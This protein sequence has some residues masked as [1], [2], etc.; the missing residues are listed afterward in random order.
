MSEKT[1]RMLLP[2]EH[3]KTELEIVECRCG[4]HL[5]LDA[6]YLDQVGDVVVLCPSCDTVL[7]TSKMETPSDT[8]ETGEK[9]YIPSITPDT[10]V[11]MLELLRKKDP[12]VVQSMFQPYHP[13]LPEIG[14]DDSPFFAADVD[15]IA[16]LAN[17]EETPDGDTWFLSVIGLINSLFGPS[18]LGNGFIQTRWD[19][20]QI[21]G[22]ELLGF[23]IDPL[24][25]M[26]R[27]IEAARQ[28]RQEQQPVPA[29]PLVVSVQSSPVSEIPEVIPA[30]ELTLGSFS[31][32]T[33]P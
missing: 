30:S 21:G 18:E 24:T 22:V 33:P 2:S 10:V 6:T 31:T 11:R 12:V 9:V 14:A 23:R 4:F 16:A 27:T 5:G 1:P 3:Q 19:V 7:D 29:E 13:C 25:G 28:R 17:P 26:G 15:V 20:S 8:I 32:D